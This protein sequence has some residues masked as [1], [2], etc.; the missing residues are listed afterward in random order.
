MHWLET[1]KGLKAV[2]K[3]ASPVCDPP[4]HAVLLVGRRTTVQQAA[5]GA[6][7]S[8]TA[9]AA[10]AA[11]RRKQK[12]QAGRDVQAAPAALAV[13]VQD[14]AWLAAQRARPGFLTAD[15]SGGA[16]ARKIPAF[17]EVDD[18]TLDELQY[19]R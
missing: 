5:A 14:D 9:A 16:E 17:N 18:A 13:V 1:G 3:A 7:S 8:A 6:A 10:A 11:P 12:R 19:V 4:V 2:G 15:I